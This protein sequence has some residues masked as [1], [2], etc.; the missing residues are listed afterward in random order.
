MV[1]IVNPLS[2]GIEIFRAFG[3]F[4]VILPFIL[5]YA[6]VFGVLLKTKIFGDEK[7]DTTRN[8]SNVIALSTAF[9]VISATDVVEQMMGVIPQATFMLVIVLFLLMIY[10]ML[11]LN[12][13]EGLFGSKSILTGGGMK[14]A[15]FGVIILVFLLMIDA[16]SPTGIPI[17]RGLNE[18][19]LGNTAFG[20]EGS[21]AMNM[22]I[23]L[24]FA[25]GIPLAIIGFLSRNNN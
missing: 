1:E 2:N 15:A 11:G 10:A 5:V 3:F 21:E 13:D 4:N 7:T 18:I 17:L 16:G 6:I 9:F 20:L 14:A 25:V 22:I 23:G 24:S 8:I 12:A 19:L